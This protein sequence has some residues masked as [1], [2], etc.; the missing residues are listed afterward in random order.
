M[1]KLQVIALALTFLVAIISLPLAAGP[2][3]VAISHFAGVWS[4]VRYV[5]EAGDDLGMEVEIDDEPQPVAFVTLCEGACS[6]GKAWPAIIHDNTITF[7][8]S[9][10]LFGPN[11]EAQEPLKLTFVGRLI[12]HT[13]A[14]RQLN[15]P[16]VPEEMLKR[17]AHPKPR[18]T[19]KL[20]CGK[21]SC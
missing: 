6:G 21:A 14:V 4:S 3:L 10:A 2:A 8:V 1:A 16:D 13:L 18:E 9:E 19:Q 5:A 15:A 20:G 17:V 11:G 7:S 12:G